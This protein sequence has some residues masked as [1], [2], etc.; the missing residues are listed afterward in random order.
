MARPE[1]ERKRRNLIQDIESHLQHIWDF[2]TTSKND[3]FFPKKCCYFGKAN[4]SSEGLFFVHCFA[5]MR[6]SICLYKQQFTIRCSFLDYLNK[7]RKLKNKWKNHN[8]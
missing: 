4:F 5:C 3:S 8:N 6:Q 2:E 7:Y 1:H